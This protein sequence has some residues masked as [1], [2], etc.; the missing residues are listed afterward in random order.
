MLL[1]YLITKTE[2]QK[3]SLNN[4]RKRVGYD[5]ARIVTESANLGTTHAQAFRMLI[6]GEDSPGSN[7]IPKR[8]EILADI[9]ILEA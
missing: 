5:E 4:W 6:E 7:Y 9:L 3:Q 2:E 1:Q 8:G